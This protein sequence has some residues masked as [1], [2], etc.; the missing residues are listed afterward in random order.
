MLCFPLII[1]LLSSFIFPHIFASIEGQTLEI[2]M[3]LLVIVLLVFANFFLSAMSTFMLLEHKDENT[4]Q[5]IG[6]TPIGTKG[7]LKFKMIYIYIMTVLSNS[8][9]IYGTKLIAGDKY[10]IGNIYLFDNI[11]FTHIFSFT[12]VSGI[13]AVSLSL[14]QAAIAK[15]K[16]ESFALIKGTGLLA[17]IPMLIVF[18]TFQDGLQ[19]VLGIFP[20]FWFIKAIIQE[21]FTYPSSAN[22]SYTMY[23]IIGVVYNIILL[24]GAYSLFNKKVQY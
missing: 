22:L 2:T 7:Y 9:V 21:L 3:L 13:F 15:N 23:F 5:T 18:D 11:K 14:F 8:I 17:I 1:L 24:M 6:V 20:N 16:V 4:L 12:F 19:Y 10:I